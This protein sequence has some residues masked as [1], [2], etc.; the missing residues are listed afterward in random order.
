M[1]QVNFGALAPYLPQ[2]LGGLWLTI[3]VSGATV[4]ISLP[5]GLGGA[6]LRTSRYP[7]LRVLAAAYVQVMRNVPILLILFI[8]FFELANAGL[9]L[10]PAWAAVAAMSINGTAYAIEIFRG[11]LAGIPP[12]Q[13]EAAYSLGLHP[14]QVFR[15][16]VL[17]QLMRISFPALGNQVVG[18]V[19]ASSVVFFIGV[20]DL[21]SASNQI[22]S[23]TF[24]YFEVFV[25]AGLMY[26]TA[27]QTINRAWVL[28]GRRWI[29]S[30]PTAGK[31]A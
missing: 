28:L 3:L 16:V 22:G 4:A 26:V 19:L 2:L 30:E 24:R 11:G 29:G 9:P 6:L 18:T 20:E 8:V 25:I 15:Y 1:S 14:V 5:L 21:S 23:H 10:P 17:P 12:G 31:A 7:L 27:A 13:Y